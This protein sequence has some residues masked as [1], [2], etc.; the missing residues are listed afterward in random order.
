[1]ALRRGWA[2]IK[3][4]TIPPVRDSV[5]FSTSLFLQRF[6]TE[7]LG[8][9]GCRFRPNGF[10]ADAPFRLVNYSGMLVE[11]WLAYRPTAQPHREAVSTV[12]R[13]LE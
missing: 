12:Q 11:W 5:V 10:Q 8:N 6:A 1:M 13:W 9:A 7:L 4:A 2:L 3:T